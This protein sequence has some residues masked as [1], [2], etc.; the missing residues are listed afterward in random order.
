MKLDFDYTKV[1]KLLEDYSIIPGWKN[2][3]VEKR[4]I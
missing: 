3:R 1:I 4:K 2:L